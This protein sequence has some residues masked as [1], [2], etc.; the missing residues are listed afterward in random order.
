MKIKWC[1]D[2]FKKNKHC[3]CCIELE[4]DKYCYGILWIFKGIYFVFF[5]IIEKIKYLFKKNK[6]KDDIPF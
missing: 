3:E 1:S 2:L 5:F 4:N 6:I